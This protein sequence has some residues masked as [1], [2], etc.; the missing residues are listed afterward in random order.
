MSCPKNGVILDPLADSGTT[1]VVAKRMG[2]K[3]IMVDISY[4]KVL[5]MR[6]RLGVQ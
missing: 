3:F 5:A 2:R 1:G 4:D 6:G